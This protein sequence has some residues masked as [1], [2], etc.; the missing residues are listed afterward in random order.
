MENIMKHTTL[1]TCIGALLISA[2]MLSYADNSVTSNVSN[3]V[4]SGVSTTERAVD[5]SSITALIK[6]KYL[7]DSALKS[8]KISVS[9]TKGLVTLTGEV[10]SNAQYHKAIH[11]AKHTNGVISVNA[12]GLKIVTKP[13]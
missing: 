2:S 12:D 4:S 7:A 3:S 6:S 11:I 8:F 13:S 5:D 10:G 1:Y 9:T